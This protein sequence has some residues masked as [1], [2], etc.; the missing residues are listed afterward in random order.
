MIDVQDISNCVYT[1]YGCFIHR[2]FILATRVTV[3]ITFAR[4]F[5]KIYTDLILL[6]LQTLRF[7]S[8]QFLCR[9]VRYIHKYINIYI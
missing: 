6:L 5:C 7:S 8:A 3:D 4:T 9:D 1:R 2:L